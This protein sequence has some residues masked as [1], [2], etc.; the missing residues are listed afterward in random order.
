MI[1][2]IVSSSVLILIIAG[3]RFFLKGK[4]SLRLQYA[5]WGLVLV[6]L[7]LPFSVGSSEISVINILP[8]NV[9]Q[10]TAVEKEQNAGE[11]FFVETEYGQS[12]ASGDAVVGNTVFIGTAMEN[13][14]LEERSE[15][16]KQETGV[17][18]E[19]EQRATDK[20]RWEMQLAELL[21]IIW[22]LGMVLVG[23]I[24][25]LVN[26][27]FSKS[28]KKSRQK[29]EMDNSAGLR[30]Y[31]TKAVDTPCLF[32]LFPPSIYLTPEAMKNAVSLHHILEHESTHYRHWD[33]IWSVLRGV[34]LAAHWY[35]PLVW[36]AAA[37]SRADAELAC[38]ESTIQRI[39]EQERAEYGRTLIQMT[40]QKRSG[41]FV[42]AT[43]MTG[44]KR[45]IRERIMLIAKRP[46]MAAVTLAG[47][48]VLAL[49]AVG[50]TFTGG[51][52]KNPE[53]NTVSPIVTPGLTTTPKITITPRITEKPE[54]NTMPGTTENQNL[55]T[56]PGNTQVPEVTLVPTP[57]AVLLEHREMEEGL[58]FAT[59]PTNLSNS[60]DDYAY[61]YYQNQEKAVAALEQAMEK[62]Q[63]DRGWKAGEE[64][65][66]IYVIYQENWWN[67]TR[68]GA[69]VGRGR[70]EAEDAKAIFSICLEAAEAIG[71]QEPVR[72]EKI[73]GI[74]SATLLHDGATVLTDGKALWK[75][76]QWLANSEE[77]FGGASCWFTALLTLELENGEQ[78]T[79]SIATD[80]CGTWM[81]EGVFYQYAHGN[82]E[83]FE[84]FAEYGKKVADEGN[85]VHTTKTEAE[86]VFDIKTELAAVETAYVDMKKKLEEDG[87]LNQAE[88]NI[89]AGECSTLWEE[90]METFWKLLEPLLTAEE[91]KKLNIE[92]QEWLEERDVQ[93]QNIIEAY[94]GGSITGLLVGQK[95][96][97]LTRARVYELAEYLAEKVEQ[98]VTLSTQNYSGRYVDTQGTDV[99][100]SEL[101]LSQRTDGSYEAEIGLYRLTTLSGTAVLEDDKLLFEDNEI[102][103]KGTIRISEGMAEFTVTESEFPYL[104]SGEAFGFTKSE[105]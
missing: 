83:F 82:E 9:L 25:F 42:T 32:G 74:Q 39:G 3:L 105:E 43:T 17:P 81:S 69:M 12:E 6:R 91:V 72:P 49:A 68:D 65:L 31:K 19:G 58:Y 55:S 51:G 24:L 28:L 50:C 87:S 75:L 62:V 14:A 22:L 8:E 71:R 44:S 98:T 76:E 35:N 29:Q 97:E 57:A 18:V 36:W 70:V 10:W 93:I 101:I 16:V 92:Q 53:N 41:L 73:R 85:K 23:S 60:G 64:S 21:K 5:L 37:L 54:M 94:A 26:V 11:N 88:M 59:N 63:Q 77:L 61:I 103:V 45:G 78:V 66:G 96:A 86:N 89:L 95:K 4:I 67:F 15:M 1:E 34:C 102:Q 20:V 79:I 52:T 84:L 56:M 46:K 99:V 40:C 104:S 48:I 27:Q 47:V 2:W 13:G 38:D 90:A 33:H 7:L 30:V 100:Y 80:S